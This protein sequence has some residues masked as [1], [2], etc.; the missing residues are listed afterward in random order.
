[1][2]QGKALAAKQLDTSGIQAAA[3]DHPFF[4]WIDLEPNTA[5]WFQQCETNCISNMSSVCVRT[6]DYIVSQDKPSR[7]P[8]RP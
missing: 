8:K 6:A 1:M 2:M 5:V 4:Q 7:E 3:A